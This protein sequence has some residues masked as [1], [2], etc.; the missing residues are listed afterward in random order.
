MVEALLAKKGLSPEDVKVIDYQA[1][2]EQQYD[3]LADSIRENLDMDKV[4]EILE[5]GI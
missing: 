5:R 4:K 1:Y 3:L 2:K